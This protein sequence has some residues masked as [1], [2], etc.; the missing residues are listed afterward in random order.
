MW[1]IIIILLPYLLSLVP[2]K[3]PYPNAKQ[4][5]KVNVKKIVF[6]SD[7]NEISLNLSFAL[8]TFFLSN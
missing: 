1:R 8:M 7:L 5:N 2:K 3:K 4:G 6:S